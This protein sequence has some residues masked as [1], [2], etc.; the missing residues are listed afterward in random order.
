M[1]FG[2]VDL[3]HCSSVAPLVVSLIRADFIADTGAPNNCKVVTPVN[4]L[5]KGLMAQPLHLLN[6]YVNSLP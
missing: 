3:S 1:Q 2:V 4:S 6:T 5:V